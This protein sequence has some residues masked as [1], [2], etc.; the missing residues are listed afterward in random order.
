MVRR[1]ALWHSLA[2]AFTGVSLGLPPPGG[3]V[4]RALASPGRTVL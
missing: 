1:A 4:G 3:P 2:A